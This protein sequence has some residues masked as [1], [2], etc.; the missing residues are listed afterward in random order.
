[1]PFPRKSRKPREPL[2]E[3]ALYHYAVKALGR[4][5]RTEVELRRL[6]TARAEPGDSGEAGGAG[7]D[8]PAE[9]AWLPRRSAL[10]PK[11]TRGCGRRTRSSA[12][13]AC[14]R[15]LQQKG[16]PPDRS[17]KRLTPRYGETDEEKLA[18]AHLERKRIRKPV[19]EKELA[20]VMRRLVA[21]GFSTGT[22]YKVLRKWDVPGGRAGGAGKRGRRE[23]RGVRRSA[24]QRCSRSTTAMARTFA[25]RQPRGTAIFSL[26]KG[27]PVLGLKRFIFSYLYLRSLAATA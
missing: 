12:R 8:C 19:N 11:P 24:R 25:G 6:M 10:T 2:N 18:R 5:M 3:A 4:Q 22:I 15:I 23:T 16:I 21:A 7:G 20:R 9:G 14:S 17:W 1:M 26:K 27:L 13:G